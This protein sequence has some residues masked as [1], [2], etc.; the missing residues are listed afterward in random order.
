MNRLE[1]KLYSCIEDQPLVYDY[2]LREDDEF[3][4]F[5]KEYKLTIKPLIKELEHIIIK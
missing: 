1:I 4:V 2:K 3:F 5:E